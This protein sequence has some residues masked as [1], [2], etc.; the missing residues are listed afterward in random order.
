MKAGQRRW[1]REEL[2]LAINLYNKLPFGK[3]HKANPDIIA[4][5]QLIGRTPSSIALKLGNLASLDPSLA[6]RGIRGAENSSKLDRAVWNEFYQDWEKAAYESEKLLANLKGQELRAEQYE[7]DDKEEQYL[8]SE[9]KQLVKVR[10]S[11][12]LFRQSVLS[13]YNFR[14]CVTG[15]NLPS[16]LVAGHI[17]PWNLD[18]QNR[19]NPRNGIAING[20]HDKAYE[21][22]LITILPNYKIKVSSQLRIEDKEV[23]DRY[24]IQY[25]GKEINLPSKFL[26]DPQFLEYHYEERFLR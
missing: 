25:D 26:P 1:S 15:I 3:M 10:V 18:E 20:L 17:K 13:S 4:L 14:C 2:I 7:L 9:R 5:A 12:S 16:L 21:Q 22:G 11:Q 6:E 8:G 19:L 23:L 24:F